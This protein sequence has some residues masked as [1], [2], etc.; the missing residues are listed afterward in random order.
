MHCWSGEGFFYYTNYSS[1]QIL[2]IAINSLGAGEIKDGAHDGRK[3]II[4]LL[5]RSENVADIFEFAPS[6]FAVDPEHALNVRCWRST[7]HINTRV[8]YL[9]TTTRLYRSS[10]QVHHVATTDGP[11]GCW[12]SCNS[13]AR[14]SVCPIWSTLFKRKETRYGL[15]EIEFIAR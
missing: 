11:T 2:T 3:E 10:L 14:R 5:S 1:Y 6:V 4:E 15:L 8:F 12:S 9:H 7:L 13:T